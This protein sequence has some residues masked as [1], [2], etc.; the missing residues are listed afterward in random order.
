[1]ILS[2][3]LR[4]ALKWMLMR[5]LQ[6]NLRISLKSS[7]TFKISATY[8]DNIDVND[9]PNGIDWPTIES[10]SRLIHA[11]GVGLFVGLEREWRGKEAGLRTF[12]F[13]ALLGG[14]GGMTGDSFAL[15]SV[16]MLGVLIVFLNVQALQANKGVE[17]TTSA[18]LLVVGLT[19]VLCGKGHSTIPTAIAVISAGMLAWKERMAVFSQKLTAEELRSAILLAILTFAI[20]PVLPTTAI[21]PWLLIVPK[22]AWMTVMLIAGISF[23]N[24]TLWKV[25]G[26]DGLEVTGFF[27]GLVNS[28]ITVT[29]LSVRAREAQGRL[30]EIVYRGVLLASAAM[31]SRNA[32]ILAFLAFGAF[33]ASVIP[34]L[35]ILVPCGILVTISKYMSIHNHDEKFSLQLTSPFSLPSTLKFAAIFLIIQV[36]GGV[37]QDSFGKYGLYVISIIGGFVSSASAVASAGSLAIH[38]KVSYSVAGVASV[39]ASLSSSGMTATI[40]YRLSG[41]GRLRIKV[42]R[43][44]LTT[45][46]LAILGAVLQKE[47]SFQIPFLN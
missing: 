15:V 12:G 14:L 8:D 4:G 21:D 17:L 20:Y 30:D 6:K 44:L 2:E 18:A 36:I 47:L 28:T 41:H 35:L 33:K 38:G 16:A 10:I 46:L 26:T 31:A 1:M 11:L 23:V 43:A 13:A 34:L 3:S 24:Y 5:G 27:G 40:V 9:L 29:E 22:S 19:G 25:F 7:D 45:I 39:L 32:L 37:A 42:A